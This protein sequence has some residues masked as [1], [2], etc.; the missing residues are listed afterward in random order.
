MPKQLAS[1]EPE[2]EPEER[3]GAAD[4]PNSTGSTSD[5]GTHKTGNTSHSRV[6]ENVVSKS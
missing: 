3:S 6:L 4:A 1:P 5:A 2:P